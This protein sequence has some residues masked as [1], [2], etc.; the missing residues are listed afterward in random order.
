MDWKTY[1]GEETAWEMR[2]WKVTTLKVNNKALLWLIIN[3]LKSRGGI[4][5]QHLPWCAGASPLTSGSFSCVGRRQL[6]LAAQGTNPFCISQSYVNTCSFH[7]VNYCRWYKECSP[8]LYYLKDYYYYE[9]C[10]NPK[11]FF[12][13]KMS[14]ILEHKKM[15]HL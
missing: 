14:L 5:G 15:S 7:I 12:F 4:A 1:V 11:P 3:C 9:L 8:G 10:Y 13:K 6:A 2:G